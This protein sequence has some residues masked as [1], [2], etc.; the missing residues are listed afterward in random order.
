[1]PTYDYRCENGHTFE[2]FQ[3]MVDPPL[4]ICPV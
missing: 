2:E 3:S 1:M 4:E